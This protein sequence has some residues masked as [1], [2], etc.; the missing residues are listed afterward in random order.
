VDKSR[1]ARPLAGNNNAGVW[2]GNHG[3]FPATS[4]KLFSL[5]TALFAG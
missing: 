3:N 2:F 4:D 5:P 1:L